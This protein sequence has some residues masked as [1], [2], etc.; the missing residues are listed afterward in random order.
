MPAS[1]SVDG[2]HRI[3]SPPEIVRPSP[4]LVGRPCDLD[5]IGYD[6][7]SE[8]SPPVVKGSREELEDAAGLSHDLGPQVGHLYVQGHGEGRGVGSGGRVGGR[9]TY[10][11]VRADVRRERQWCKCGA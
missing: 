11:Y 9:G 8:R 6:T 7:V 1:A 4:H 2:Q 3:S 5:E 10:V